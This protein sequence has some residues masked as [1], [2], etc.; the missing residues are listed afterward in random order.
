MERNQAGRY[1]KKSL[2]TVKNTFVRQ[3]LEMYRREM[4][5]V[6]ILSRSILNIDIFNLESY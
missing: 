1:L 2:N 3:T 6:Q 4:Y 5:I